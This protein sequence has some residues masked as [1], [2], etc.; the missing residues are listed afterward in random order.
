[1]EAYSSRTLVTDIYFEKGM[2]L[3][4]FFK[5]ALSKNLENDRLQKNRVQS[6]FL[7]HLMQD[8]SGFFLYFFQIMKEATEIK[9]ERHMS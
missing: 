7:I 3:K 1:M 9:L 8:H 6:L 4:F 5:Q 2:W